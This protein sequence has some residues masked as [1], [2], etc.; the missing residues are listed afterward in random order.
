MGMSPSLFPCSSSLRVLTEHSFGAV[1][2]EFEVR[3]AIENV[4]SMKST[5]AWVI[6]VSL[7]SLC[8]RKVGWL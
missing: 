7:V 5:L 8:V 3:D 1:L 2:E 4:L 6:E